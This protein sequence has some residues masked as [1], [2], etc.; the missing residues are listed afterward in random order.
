[1]GASVF[2]QYHQHKGHLST[3]I[4]HYLETKEALAEDDFEAAQLSVSNLKDEVVE[5]KEMNNHEEHAQM[6]AE[7]H[8]SMVKAVTNAAE[9]EDI[10]ELRSSFKDISS[11]LIKALKNQGFD[12]E[13]L[14]LQYCPMAD[15]GEGAQWISDQ[16]MVI[17]PYMGQKMPGCGKT[18][19]MIGSDH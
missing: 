3:L 6:H 18:E 9:A 8:G 17:N 16:E 2:A 12:E 13:S 7:H 1:M 11:N 4:D 19:G 14:Y 10:D 5:N 15:N